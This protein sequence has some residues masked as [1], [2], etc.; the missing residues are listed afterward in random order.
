[1]IVCLQIIM[2]L[3]ATHVSLGGVAMAEPYNSFL[4]SIPVLNFDFASIFLPL[5]CATDSTLDH[6]HTLVL[7]TLLP[8]FVL[9]LV[10][11][12]LEVR[13]FQAAKSAAGETL[14]TRRKRERRHNMVKYLAMNLMILAYPS[15]CR[16]I[17][18]SFRC[19]SYVGWACG[20][21]GWVGGGRSALGQCQ[22]R[23]NVL[24]A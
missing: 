21:C 24:L 9:L 16:K 8:I 15:I 2:T 14:A 18:Y 11:A 13:D 12:V 3:G 19:E 1:M 10:C 4:A 5:S 22:P 17:C 7:T 6:L 23:P 20:E